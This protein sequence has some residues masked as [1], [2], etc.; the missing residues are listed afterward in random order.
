MHPKNR[1]TTPDA[2]RLLGSSL[3][4]FL[5]SILSLAPITAIGAALCMLT[6]DPARLVIP[7]ALVCMNLCAAIGGFCASKRQGGAP[8]PCGLLC[9]GV[10]LVFSYLLGLA[11]SSA[12]RSFSFGI[13]LALRILCIVFS[14]LGALL[15]TRRSKARHRRRQKR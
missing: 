3:F 13:G 1:H 14:I 8:L 12:E 4:G 2:N 11:F 15:G 6:D 5:G 9:G 7:I 10:W